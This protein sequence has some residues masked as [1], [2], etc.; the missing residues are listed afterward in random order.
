M[1][2]TKRRMEEDLR[3]RGYDEG[4]IFPGIEEGAVAGLMA[5]CVGLSLVGSF[6]GDTDDM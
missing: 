5:G 6:A 4:R 2:S 3:E 1:V